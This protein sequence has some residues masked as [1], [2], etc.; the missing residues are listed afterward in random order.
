MTTGSEPAAAIEVT[1]LEKV[2]PG[3]SNRAA[4]HALRGVYLTIPQGSIF[5]LLGPNGAGKST[6]INILAGLVRKSG[7]RVRICGLDLDK[8][9]RAARSTIGVVPQELTLDPYF[10][11]RAALDLQAGL[12]GIPKA[13]RRTDELLAALSLMDK[14][15]APARRCC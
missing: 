1:A 7:G 8:A 6:I 11:A 13:A 4:K 10:P 15:D 3:A 12:F 9:P 2:Y 14:A 5:G